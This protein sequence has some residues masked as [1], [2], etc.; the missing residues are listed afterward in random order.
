MTKELALTL[1]VSFIVWL[2]VR[3]REL[4]PMT[5]GPLWVVLI[6]IVIV[7]TRSVSAWSV[8]EFDIDLT[9][10]AYL[11]G[12]PLDRN[13]FLLLMLCGAVALWRRGVAWGRILSSNPWF[14]A[15]LF[16]CG[17][18]VLWSDYPV[19]SG[20]RWMKEIG[21]VIMVLVVFTEHDP[22]QAIRAVLARTAYIA[23]PLSVTLIKYFPQFGR[24]YGY[25]SGEIVYTGVTVEKN[26]LGI[27]IFTCALFLVW[28]LLE[29]GFS[30][31]YKTDLFSRIVLLL[32]SAWLIVIAK[33]ATALVCLLLSVCLLL[34]MHR[35]WAREQLRYLG[36]YTLVLLLVVVAVYSTPSLTE[37]LVKA[38]GRDV[39]FTGRTELWADVLK[40]RINPILGTGYQA[41]WLGPGGTHMWQKYYFHPIQAH[42][43]FLETYL[44]CGVI[45]LGLLL[46]MIVSTAQKVRAGL[47]L[48]NKLAALFFPF[49]VATIFYNWT[50]AMISG[51]NLIW[52]MLSM[53][54]LHDPFSEEAVPEASA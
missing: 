13:I 16:Y 47:L 22:L 33:S 46:A 23:I 10:A 41:F 37:A 7:G 53:A 34:L 14:F 15:F 30:T 54:A 5:S 51:L 36:I 27:V 38:V 28:D 6:W 49:L 20:K 32:M 4:R 42:N 50:E 9:P 26:S 21:N 44:N 12:S 40:E 39:T 18:S 43:G 45:G 1:C 48:G 2:F 19:V 3:D 8:Q 29:T 52:I 24:R 11:E 31:L 25:W 17:I 35:E